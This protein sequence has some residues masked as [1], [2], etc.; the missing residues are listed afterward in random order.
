[1]IELVEHLDGIDFIAACTVLTGEPPPKANGCDRAGEPR[2][3]V[4][5][6]FHY[7]DESG[8][9][10][11]AVE[12]IEYQNAD[13]SFVVTKEGKRKK[14]FRQKRPDADKPDGWLWNVD[15]VPPLPYRLPELI[16]AIAVG[17]AVLIVEGEARSI[18]YDPGISRR[19]AAPAARRSGAP[20]MRHPC[21][22]PMRVILPDNDEAGR[23]HMNV[24]AAS[25]Q[26]VA[27][28]IRVLELPGLPPKG[29]IVDWATTGGTAEQLHT[30]IDDAPH[31]VAGSSS[32][33]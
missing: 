24:V 6:E 29:D 1:M 23:A 22:A 28:S 12:R 10:L 21:A 3:I 2:K 16:E 25:L 13:G 9:V 33:R 31:R 7:G 26:G 27:A 20:N 19:R 11:F 18:S 14:T 8:A 30:L 15:G 5:A 4:T 32:H 17:S